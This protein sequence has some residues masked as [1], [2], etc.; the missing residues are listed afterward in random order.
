MKPGSIGEPNLAALIGSGIG[1]IT[2]LIA[3]GVAPAII[4]Q[5]PRLMLAHP[6]IGLICFVLGGAFGW[7]V[8]GLLGSRLARRRHAQQGYILGGLIG[9]LIPFTAFVFL[10]WV[11][12]TY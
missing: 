12:W 8:G 9:G 4:D 6:T 2:G 11:L 5:N 7:L 3:I 1:S 10:G